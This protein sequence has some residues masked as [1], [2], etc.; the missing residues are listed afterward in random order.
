MEAEIRQLY[1]SPS[2]AVHNFLCRCTACSVSAREYVDS[3]SIAYVRTGNFQFK[4]FRNDL[5]VYH[6]LFLVSKPGYEYRVGHVHRL[7]DECTVFRI[8]EEHLPMVMAQAPEYAAFFRNSDRQSIVIPATAGTEHLHH[9]I[10]GLLHQP[11]VPRL[12]IDSLVTTLL[13][14]VLSAGHR[15]APALNDRQKRF[16]LPAIEAVKEHVH[17]HFTEDLALADLAGV[18]HLSPYHFNRLFRK[19]TSVTPYQ[20]MLRVRLEQA[21]LQ[22]RETTRPVTDIAFSCGFNSLENFS[23]AYKKMY[24]QSPTVARSE[25][26]PRT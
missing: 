5:D 3:L 13:L 6:G 4:V 14:R 8:P 7:P 12:R 22:L 23:A 10:F 25:S 9:C 16:H 24:G 11:R 2:F 21:Q 20:Y 17:A 26:R 15:P 18:G 19:I 1:H